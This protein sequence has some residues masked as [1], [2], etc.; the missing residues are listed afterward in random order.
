MPA[1]AA[2]RDATAR[3]RDLKPT[4]P[5]AAKIL[6]GNV[7]GWFEKIGRGLYQLSNGGPRSPR[8]MAGSP[9]RKPFRILN[10]PQNDAL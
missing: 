7:Y 9:A 3:P 2:M 8:E 1:A 6:R 5:D 4:I 10:T